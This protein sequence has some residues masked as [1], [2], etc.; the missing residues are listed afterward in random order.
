MDATID[1][2]TRVGLGFATHTDAFQ[3]GREA[4]QAAKS[5]LME[6]PVSLVLIVGPSSVYFKDFIEGARLVLG[7]DTLVALP[8]AHTFSNETTLPNSCFV[9]ALQTAS[10]RVS[11]ASDELTNNNAL[12]GT[13]ALIS[14]FRRLRGNMAREFTHRG[15]LIFSHHLSLANKERISLFGADM[16]L[17]SW[18]LGGSTV[19]EQGCPAMCLNKT[20]QQGLI[21]VE[22]LSLTPW[23]VGSVEIG[24]FMSQTDVYRE[25]LKTAMRDALGNMQSRPA[26]FG[27]VLF[28]LANGDAK[29]PADILSTAAAILPHVPLLGVSTTRNFVRRPQRAVVKENDSIL[30][31]LVPA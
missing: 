25:A 10:M 15:A 11:I 8:T 5:Q 22:F 28:D 27:L 13:T 4:A 9:V 7:E 18:I 30:V 16:G 26:C 31:L 21:G 24:P 29:P 1:K 19:A 3:C 2:S 23:G 20:V 14:Q 12:R 17:E 6:G